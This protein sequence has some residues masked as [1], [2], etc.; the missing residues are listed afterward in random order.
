MKI[1]AL[2]GDWW[3]YETM[4]VGSC[5]EAVLSALL[6]PVCMGVQ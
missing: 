4:V 1:P 2:G 6:Q 3:D 5:T